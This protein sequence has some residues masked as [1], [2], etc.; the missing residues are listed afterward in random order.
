MT[1]LALPR[2]KIEP[3]RTSRAGGGPRLRRLRARLRASLPSI[4]TALGGGVVWALAMAATASLGLYG[5]GWQNVEKARAVLVIYMAGAF[6]S[7]PLALWGATFASLGRSREVAFAA[8]FLAL[9]T[10]TIGIT[11]AVYALDYRHYYVQWHAD[12]FTAPWTLQFVFTVGGALYQFAVLGLRLYVPLGLA[13]LFA[14]S[15]WF[16]LRAR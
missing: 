11:A 14:A 3:A 4:G 9:A 1:Q 10:L 16:A 15:L 6:V 13:A 7:F 8:A 2:D 12:P 5:E